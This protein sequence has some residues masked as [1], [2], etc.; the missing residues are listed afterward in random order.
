MDNFLFLKIQDSI[1]T[2]SLVLGV[3]SSIIFIPPLAKL[4]HVMGF[5][6]KPNPRKIHHHPVSGA[7]GI[8]IAIGLLLPAFLWA[9]YDPLLFGCLLGGL[10]ILF[11]GI[12]DDCRA[13]SQS[14]KVLFQLIAIAITMHSGLLIEHVPFF[15]LDPAPGWVSYPLTII[16][17]LGI[18]NATNLFDGLDGLA[19]GCVLLSLGMIAIF[20]YNSGGNVIT[21]IAL[22]TIGATMGFL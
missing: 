16:F 5:T 19:G 8:G 9:P 18:T 1:L 4:F 20:S 21:L 3:F 12:W 22:A 7:G 14:A 15:G 17:L 13:L 11:G 10:V 2:Y 6:D